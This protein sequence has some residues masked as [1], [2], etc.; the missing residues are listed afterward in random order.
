MIAVFAVVVVLVVDVEAIFVEEV[1][2]EAVEVVE[3][4]TDAG[5][6]GLRCFVAL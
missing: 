6:D 3:V 2:L 1:V 5:G 4:D